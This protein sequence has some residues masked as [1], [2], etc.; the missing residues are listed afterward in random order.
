MALKGKVSILAAIILLAAFWIKPD[1]S[2][3][4]FTRTDFIAATLLYFTLELYQRLVGDS[5]IIGFASVVFHVFIFMTLFQL[6]KD[7]LRN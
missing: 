6:D 2:K 1:S 5:N 7:I 3:N 4:V